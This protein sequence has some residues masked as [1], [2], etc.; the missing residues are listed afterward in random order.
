MMQNIT[1]CKLQ[2]GK[3]K[4]YKPKRQKASQSIIKVVRKIL[5]LQIFDPIGNT[6]RNKKIHYGIIMLEIH[7]FMTSKAR[8]RQLTITTIQ[9]MKLPEPQPTHPFT[10]LPLIQQWRENLEGRIPAHLFQ[11]PPKPKLVDPFST[12]G[13]QP[14]PAGRAE[15]K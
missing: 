4:N 12:A 5:K 11:I 13:S 9:N 15:F 3:T 10:P 7:I 6:S 8:G 2:C 14:Q 1:H